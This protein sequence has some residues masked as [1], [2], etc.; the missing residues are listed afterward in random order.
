[1]AAGKQPAEGRHLLLGFSFKWKLT[2]FVVNASSLWVLWMVSHNLFG[3]IVFFT[4]ACLFSC[5]GML[6]CLV[7]PYEL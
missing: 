5:L 6:I 4:L 2:F 1:V 7:E 3:Y